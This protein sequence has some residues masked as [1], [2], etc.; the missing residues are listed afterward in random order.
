MFRAL[1]TEYQYPTSPRRVATAPLNQRWVG[2]TDSMSLRACLHC[3][4]RDRRPLLGSQACLPSRLT[5]AF[6]RQTHLKLILSICPTRSFRNLLLT[7]ESRSKY[8][9]IRLG[10]IWLSGYQK[11]SERRE[12]SIPST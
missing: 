9:R 8:T 12:R 5:D 10:S 1:Y 7:G 11:I 4:N 6:P 2:V 3:F